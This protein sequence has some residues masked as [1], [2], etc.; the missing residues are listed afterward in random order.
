MK[1]KTGRKIQASVD[2]RFQTD[3]RFKVFSD[4]KF[5]GSDDDND[6]D[7]GVDDEDEEE[8]DDDDDDGDDNGS[9]DEQ[10]VDEDEEHIGDVGSDGDGDDDTA[11]ISK[12]KT[13]SSRKNERLKKESKK[14]KENLE[15]RGVIY[16]SRIPPFMKPNKVRALLE[17]YG[18]ITRLYLS[19]EDKTARKRRKQSG[20]NGSK[21][22][23]EG[24]VEFA[25][26]K[27]A[28]SVALSLNNSNI[29]PNKGDFYHDDI[30]NIKYLKKFKWEYLTEKFA[31]ERRVREQKLNA[32]MLK[33]KKINQE[34]V[35]KVE[36]DKTEKHIKN[37]MKAKGVEPT[38]SESSGRKR[39][40]FQ[41]NSLGS[42]HG[43]NQAKIKKSLLTEIFAK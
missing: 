5:V 43:E 36:K 21:Q 40:F 31:Y 22:F 13:K 33:A 19:E 17:V 39:S 7:D 9:V 3:E 38:S 23:V 29:A 41:S 30:W 18:E 16:L 2:S 14:Y 25:D 34:F 10:S 42:N 11:R 28:K 26:K 1:S 8:D 12:D 37:R 15:K 27:I 4:T 6:N 32:A 35:E 20:G 24:W